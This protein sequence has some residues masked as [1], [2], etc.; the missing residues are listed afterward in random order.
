M[1]RSGPQDRP[2]RA[3]A[4]RPERP[5]R[6]RTRA[7]L[8]P[9]LLA[10]AVENASTSP[11]VVGSAELT[12]AEL[13]LQSTRLAR[14]LI[15][16]GVG[17]E[18][19]VEIA[20][21]DSAQF[22]V[23]LWAVAKTGAAI[24]CGSAPS[25]R[26]G[27]T[28]N[29]A[30][31][32]RRSALEWINLDS[33][34]IVAALASQ[35]EEPVSYADRVRQLR[36]EHSAFVLDGDVALTHEGL[37]AL[38]AVAES[39]AVA[40]SSRLRAIGSDIR[41]L[42]AVIAV[43]SKA[44][45][46]RGAGAASH[47]IGN[48]ADLVELEP[49]GSG[50]IAFVGDVVAPELVRRWTSAEWRVSNIVAPPAAGWLG[51]AGIALIAGGPITF[52]VAASGVQARVLDARLRP[53]PADIA[54]DLYISGPATARRWGTAGHTAAHLVA[55]PD[56]D[57]KRLVRTGLRMRVTR[58]GQF[59]SVERPD[60]KVLDPAYYSL[61]R[62]SRTLLSGFEEQHRATPD[63]VAL[64]AGDVRLTYREFADRVFRLA[65][66][67]VA[68]GVGPEARV[69]LAMRRGIDLVVGMYA[70]VSAGGAWVPVD[71]DHPAER[72]EYILETAE[73][74]CI[75]TTAADAFTSD[76]APV[77]E[78]DAL[79]LATYSA[80]VVTDNDRRQPLRPSNTAYVIFTSGSTGRPKGVAVSHAAVVN[81]MG[82][83][84]AEYGITAEDIYVQKTATTFDVSLWGFWLPLMSGAQLVL[85]SP[86]GHRDP[87]YIS[88]LIAEHRATLTDFV[89]SMLSVFIG[90]ATADELTTL[91]H[92]FVIGE[93]LP[94]PVAQSWYE[95]CSAG[96]HNLYG[97]TEA[98]VSVTYWHAGE[99]DAVAVPIG[100]AEWNVR[101]YVLDSRLHL[102]PPGVAGEL[103]LSGVQVA[104]GYLTRPDLTSDRFVADPFGGDGARMYRTGDLVRW[105]SDGL[106]DYIGR[107]DFQVKLR[108]QR[109]ELGEIEAD[110]LSDD[111][112]SLA[113]AVVREAATGQQLV[114]YVVPVPGADISVEALKATLARKL[115]VYML[116]DAY[117]VMDEFPLNTSGKLD[118]KALPAP[119]FDA[120][121]FRA[122]ST[123]AEEVVAKVFGQILGVERIGADDDFFDLGGNSLAATQVAARVGAALG[124]RIP[125]RVVFE[126][127]TVSALAAAIEPHVG[128]GGHKPLV[129]QPRPSRIPLS[130]AQQ[131]MWFLNQFE[132]GS[133]VYNIPLAIRLTG[134]LD[135]DAMQAAVNDVIARHES[136]RTVFPEVDG[137]PVQEIR[138]EVVVDLTPELVS[139][140]EVFA[141]AAEIVTGGFDVAVEVPIRVALLQLNDRESEFV[142][143]VVVQHI[144]ADG[145]SVRPLAHDM[146]LAYGSRTAGHAPSWPPMPVQ[147]AD[148]AI[149]QRE[150]L[151][152]PN[153]ADSIVAQQEK[154]WVTALAG[155]PLSLNLPS[156]RPRPPVATYG[157]GVTQFDI[158]GE[159]VSRLTEIGRQRGASL[160][161]VVHAAFAVL[162][163]RLSNEFDV[164]IGTPVAG[165]DEEALDP[166]VG[167]F[168]N[169]LVLRTPV[170]PAASFNEMVDLARDTDL[171]AFEH[172]DVPF[173]RLVERISPERSQAYSPLFQVMLSFQNIGQTK[174]ELPGLSIEGLEVDIPVAKY[175]LQLTLFE[176]GTGPN[177]PLIGSFNYA[178]DLFDASTVAGFEQ[179][180][181]RILE[182]VA[183]DS[184]AIVGDIELAEPSELQEI[185]S[186]NETACG[187]DGSQTLVSLFERQVGLTPDAVAVVCEGEC[188]TYAEFALRVNVL[189]RYL[190]SVGVGPESFVAVGMRRSVDMLVAIY[191]VVTAG[192]AYVPVDPD[193]PAERVE[194]I[195][196]SARP[197]VL[198]TTGGDGLGSGVV[199]VVR[200][201]EL[202]LAGVDGGALAVAAR[203]DNLA[204]VIFTS[205]STGRPK[206][207]GVSHRSI[208]NRLAWMQGAYGLTVD[209][210]V[211]QKT[212]VTFDVSVWELFWALQVGARLVIA[213]PEG[214][215]DPEYLARLIAEQGVTTAHFVPSMMAVFVA[216]DAAV[217]ASCLR[218]VFA[219]GEALP[220]QTAQRLRQLVPGVRVHNL[221]GPTEAAV[222]VTFHEVV[223]SDVVSVPI[224]APVWNT[225]LR[226]LDARLKPVPVGVPGELYLT[227]VQLA[228]G[229]VGRA[230]LTADR[231][232]ADAGG[233][234]MYRTGDLVRW[235]PGGEV[236]YIGRT[237]FQVKLRGLRIE[238]GEI[239]QALMAQ[240]AIAQAVV[241]VR[242]DGPADTLVAYVVAV[243]G[244]SVDV[245][246][247]AAEVGK[248][249]PEYM[250]PAV[251][252]VLD[253]FPLNASGKLDRKAL[254]VPVFEAREFRAASNDVE[255]VIAEVF[256]DVLGGVR[257]GIDDSFF[258]LGG[259]SILSIQLVARARARGVV[260]TPRDVFEQKT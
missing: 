35:I 236:E 15:S 36:P 28:S 33:A 176:T 150:V 34:E 56:G 244:R 132:P 52:G 128:E 8:L 130:M 21:D 122:P 250:V 147:Y 197:V 226:V 251:I 13:D 137:L 1:S 109:I 227:G 207:V 5:V 189:A 66:H 76:A 101:C 85:A 82:W 90:A 60:L 160:F 239:E 2:A 163:A 235:L 110:L 241:V 220:A 246:V 92:V 47:I 118:R 259:D 228:R 161:M 174:F 84:T 117:V 62:L 200:V 217:R 187:V 112:V 144:S 106:L 258:A 95:L 49:E 96:L 38:S 115:P 156:D 157:G 253:A 166:M 195:L 67:L 57:G 32:D 138:D 22:D 216:S 256:S 116:P 45:V 177:A 149:W 206:G 213:R 254:P 208:V 214:H 175:D 9:Q 69:A 191:A 219:S 141:K 162:L 94:G 229:Y 71:P 64:V 7:L 30:R 98:A 143:V 237:D 151:G 238:L 97:P 104:R 167:M 181:L 53:V 168:V 111:A 223:D 63:A 210:V 234:R 183:D 14:L 100:V 249:L 142:L 245:A 135:V 125:P 26:L 42:G 198:L 153:D 123:A 203:A 215:R 16:R 58:S 119:V 212:P 172:A 129:P 230:D 184:S 83:M 65:R 222:D 37:S 164:A 88:A 136:L 171:T 170:D 180:L 205:G 131:R 59:E 124:M 232:V 91:R 255:R 257:V 155:L 196:A 188:F 86:D 145:Y 218:M 68:A 17:A 127:S 44:A 80:S 121:E 113:A 165:R 134:A 233:D 70:T 18:D 78:I 192:G 105:R 79:D 103:Y 248:V 19:V 242:T 4:G 204:Y 146:V 209:D 23:A 201:D 54:G 179:R 231:F 12:Y 39:L 148:F 247:V 99:Q 108:G 221:Y 87:A 178:T 139:S 61:S 81:Q 51:T 29:S 211:V 185:A 73:P 199:P 260:F 93:A 224:G 107:T 89:P 120:K 20:T 193:H 114:A 102:V 243:E 72:I 41:L 75:L 43:G 40:D 169:T 252:V 46:V 140:S 152:S 11:A 190:R 50:V 25:A 6:R 182:V 194:Y 31:V 74:V 27:L 225:G 159:L 133:A 186:W 55:D 77:I 158:R 48:T 126:S 10:Q 3:R 240:E 202:D 24:A 154:H 173:E